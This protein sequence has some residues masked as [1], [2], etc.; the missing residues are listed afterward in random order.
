MLNC[1]ADPSHPQPSSPSA[2]S[3]TRPPLL[4]ALPPASCGCLALPLIPS[5]NTAAGGGPVPSSDHLSSWLAFTLKLCHCCGS[6]GGRHCLQRRGKVLG[7]NAAAGGV[8]KWMCSFFNRCKKKK[9]KTEIPLRLQNQIFTSE[10]LDF[11]SVC[12]QNV[13]HPSRNVLTTTTTTTTR[14]HRV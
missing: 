2:S 5:S 4:L 10:L 7:A 3:P 1:I 6:F 8:S 11:R 13:P 9:K 12:L 14:F